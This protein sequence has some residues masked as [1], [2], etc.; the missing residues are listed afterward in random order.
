M[1]ETKVPAGKIV[2]AG[3]TGFLGLNLA[4]Y[5]ADFDCEVVL[6]SRNPP[7]EQGPWQHYQWDG[8]TWDTWGDQL[9]GAT[10]LVNL[11][12]RTVDCIKTAAHCDEIL[13]SRV[14]ST[15]LLGI[16]L[17][18]LKNPPTVWVQMSTAHRY[19]DPPKVI[20]NE[21]SA[22]GYGLAPSV[23]QAWED[24]YTKSVLPE[25]RQVILRTS[26]VLGRRGGALPRLAKLTRWGLGG[27]VGSGEQ[28]ISWIH[29]HDMNLL[30][31]RAISDE[32]MQGAYLSTAPQPVSNREFM[33][34]LRQ[35]LKIPIGLPAFRWMVYIGAPLIMNTDPE[36]AL[37]GRY[38]VSR[39]LQEEGFE[40]KF[41]DVT[42][43]LFD[44][45]NQ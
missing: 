7:A 23:A 13:R 41:P 39:R 35:A 30:F 2:I 18:K 10:A 3:G 25:M 22:F 36:L 44:I 17:R 31:A 40:F 27:T 12:G 32:Q 42:S 34:G 28:G 1:T 9:E 20:C 45:Y 19:G 21:D 38:C 37:F 8:R 6:I 43:A 14:E 29:E 4:R 5:L 16:A 24:A 33:R 26:F 15:R 11:A